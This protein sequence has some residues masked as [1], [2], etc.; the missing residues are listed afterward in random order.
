MARLNRRIGVSLLAIL[1]A[2]VTIATVTIAAEAED[3]AAWMREAQWGVMNHY[4][5]D[6][7]AREWKMQMSVEKWN[8]LVDHFD[9]EGLAEQLR[10]SPEM[11][12]T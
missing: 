3:R 8:D 1:V 6:W 7:K 2:T 10:W 9:V 11:R 5:A 12:N 4:L